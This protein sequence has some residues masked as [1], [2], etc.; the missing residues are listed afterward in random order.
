[1]MRHVILASGVLVA[2]L[3]GSVPA[4]AA[5]SEG[6][7][8]M[9][10]PYVWAASIGTDMRTFQ[11]PTEASSDTSFPD[12]LDKL[13]GVFMGRV[14]GRNDRF[15]LFADFIYLADT[16]E[17]LH[18]LPARAWVQGDATFSGWE[19]ELG[20]ELADNASGL[21]N[22]RLF[23]DAV[24][25]KLDGGGRL[26]RIAPGRAGADLVWNQGAWRA[27]LGAVR[28]QRQADVAEFESATDGYTLVDA[29]LAYQA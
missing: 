24:D 20:V 8:W 5:D 11:P 25:A 19:A 16:G 12:V 14:E 10:E 21:W 6:W 17:E 2:V 29:G 4:S 3:L 27:R 7:G 22:L 1:M 9:V 18:G 15:G 13:D 23:A 28:V 26:P